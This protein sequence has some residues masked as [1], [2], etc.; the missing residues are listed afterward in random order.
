MKVLIVDDDA[1]SL[2]I[3]QMMFREMNI[4]CKTYGDPH[5]AIKEYQPFQYDILITDHQMPGMKGN[6]LVKEIKKLD[7]AIQIIMIGGNLDD[8]IKEEAAK[9]GVSE[10]IQKPVQFELLIKKCH[11]IMDYKN[12]PNAV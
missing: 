6:Q 10:F 11:E 3:F 5:K 12:T 8:S 9:Q 1:I 4:D 7:N 2:K